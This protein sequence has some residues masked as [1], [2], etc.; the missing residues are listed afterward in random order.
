MPKNINVPDEACEK[1][2]EERYIKTN[3]I[4][5]L[6]DATFLL[7]LSDTKDFNFDSFLNIANIDETINKSLILR[8]TVTDR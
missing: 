2:Y 8:C 7:N 3:E 5:A 4:T 6:F 1:I